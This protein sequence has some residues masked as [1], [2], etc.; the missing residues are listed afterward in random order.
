[1]TGQAPVR[2]PAAARRAGILDAAELEFARHGLAG[3][4]LDA[5]AERAGI[6]HPRVVQMFGSKKK[7]FLEVVDIAYGKIETAFERAEPTLTALGDAYVKL[8]RREST[9]GLVVLQG[10]AAA[11]DDDVRQAVRRRH[12]DLMKSIA[13]LTGADPAQVR[14]FFATGLVQ[15]V[16]SALDLPERRADTAWSGWILQLVDPAG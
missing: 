1:M 4:R 3:G 11:A 16:S 9:V 13:R 7:L 8:L 6:S 10:Y 15:T 14:T 5:I 12:L 2:L